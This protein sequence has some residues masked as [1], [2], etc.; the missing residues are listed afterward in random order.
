MLL[1]RSLTQ[2]TFHSLVVKFSCTLKPVNL[3]NCY[4]SILLMW[5]SCWQ[6]LII[7]LQPEKQGM[8]CF[9]FALHMPV[10]IPIFYLHYTNLLCQFAFTTNTYLDFHSSIFSPTLMTLWFFFD[11]SWIFMIIPKRFEVLSH[12]CSELYSPDSDIKHFLYTC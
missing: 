4:I 7:L 9:N 2:L 11:N 6:Q 8:R 10:Y 1:M 3:L 12:G 5:D